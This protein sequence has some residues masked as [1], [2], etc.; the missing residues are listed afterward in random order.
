MDWSVCESAFNPS[1]VRGVFELFSSGMNAILWLNKF[2]LQGFVW[3]LGLSAHNTF[4][5][6][7]KDVSEL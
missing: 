6:Y 3:I 2:L 1:R 5:T 7:L 4:I